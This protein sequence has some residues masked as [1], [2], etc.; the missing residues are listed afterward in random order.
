MKEIKENLQYIME[1]HGG[2]YAA[3]EQYGRMVHTDGGPLDEK[4]RW[5]IKV[6]ISSTSEYQFALRTHINKALAAGCTREEIEHAI[7]MIAPTAGFPRMMEGIMIL[8][9]LLGD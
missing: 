6:A 9:E 5:L 4:T 8:R 7:L 3:Y 1:K 2:I